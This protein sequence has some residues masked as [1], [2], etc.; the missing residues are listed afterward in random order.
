MKGN[1]GDKGR[2][3][4]S[5][6]RTFGR[7]GRVVPVS[8]DSL[9]EKGEGNEP[10]EE[11]WETKSRG[12]GRGSR[13]EV[14]GGTDESQGVTKR[15]SLDSKKGSKIVSISPYGDTLRN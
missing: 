9:Q 10:T 3:G 1:R 5:G 7:S 14:S 13:L 11:R 2:G 6:V 12:S 15:E 4:G 8:G